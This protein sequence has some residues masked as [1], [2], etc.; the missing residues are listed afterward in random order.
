[1]GIT[2][3]YRWL[4]YAGCYFLCSGSWAS[5][6]RPMVLAMMMSLTGETFV[7]AQIDFELC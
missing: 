4:W 5:R 7:G 2:C 6:Q 3:I 1:M